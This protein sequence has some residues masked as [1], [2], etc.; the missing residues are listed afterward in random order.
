MLKSSQM[1]T[2]YVLPSLA[3]VHVLLLLL[4]IRRA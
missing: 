1:L 4:P 2:W 3:L